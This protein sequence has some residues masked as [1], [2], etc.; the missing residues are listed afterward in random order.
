M[1][2]WKNIRKPFHFRDDLVY[3]AS[4]DKV[5]TFSCCKFLLLFFINHSLQWA[6]V[7][8]MSSLYYGA[9]GGSLLNYI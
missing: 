2:V 1:R 4:V 3:G 8:E 6:H 9:I 5:E 7:D